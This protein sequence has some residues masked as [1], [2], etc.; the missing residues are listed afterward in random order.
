MKMD[1]MKVTEEVNKMT[2]YSLRSPLNIG[3]RNI[4][5]QENKNKKCVTL[6]MMRSLVLCI[7]LL[8]A[9]FMVTAAPARAADVP[10]VAITPVEGVTGSTVLVRL[11]YCVPNTSVWVTFGTGSTGIS[12]TIPTD[13]R[14]FGS[15]ELIIGLIR[16]G[17][18]QISANDGGSVPIKSVNFK[19]LP[20]V[21]LSQAGGLV[22][23]TVEL[24]GNGFAA[25]KPIIVYL[26]DVK[27]TTSE[28][29]E[30]GSFPNTRF[31]FPPSASG[32][33][34]ILT[35][36]SEGT[37]VKSL[38]NINPRVILNPVSGCVGDTIQVS[39]AGFP[40]VANVILSYDGTDMATIPTDARGNIITTFKIPP[41]GDALHK[42]KLTDG[43]NPVI[44][45]I[46]VVPTLTISQ[47]NGWVSM[48]VTLNGTGF[49]CGN[50]LLAAFDNVKLAGSTVGQNGSFTHT[51]NI[52]KSKAGLHNINVTDGVNN[53]T[54]SFTMES[55]PPPAPGLV[56]PSEGTRFTKDARFLW[57]TVSD[58]SGVSYV[59][60]VA[61]DA[62]FSQPIIS[63]TGMM[64]TY[65]DV[66]DSAK[67][68]PGKSDLYYWRVKAVDGASNIGG[69]SVIGSFY[70]GVT[71]ESVLSD[72][73]AWTKFA[74]IGIGL[75]L[76]VFM[77]IFIRR[78]IMRVRYSDEAD[79]DEYQ[80]NEYSSEWEQSSGGNR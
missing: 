38:Y 31:V 52:P 8:A 51:F 64:Q 74:L 49:R 32:K 37:S 42:I 50:A 35:K 26:D 44:S 27:V 24:W 45:D 78:N 66:P 15:G 4:S 61:D 29:D 1:T 55:T 21:M 7:A 56:A 18:Y 46:T 2:K 23:D 58:P 19:V 12:V 48:G 77:V 14:G 28:T 39:A 62:R 40:A 34:T 33:H 70:K 57:E 9:G 16:G 69:W 63:Q 73:P 10:T 71:V 53:R 22:G 30:L 67:T 41:S 76:F 13:D 68:L 72:M 6:W 65:L 79:A 3:Q 43:L 47:D 75:L 5:A 25:K 60:E 36:D 59:I 20:S 54:V 11:S 80:D 17:A